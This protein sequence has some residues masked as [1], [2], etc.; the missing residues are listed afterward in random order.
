MISAV[1]IP[2]EIRR[3]LI[4]NSNKNQKGILAGWLVWHFYEMPRLLFLVWN[5]FISFGA[6]FFSVP[7]LISTL[8][9]PWRRY[10]WRYPRGFNIGGY[11]ETFVSNMFSRIVG[12]VC[13]SV[14]VVVGLLAMV[15]IFVLGSIAIL[16]WFLAPFILV[17]LVFFL[18]Y[19][20]Q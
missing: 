20:P 8:F 19:A 17:I 13:R 5:N 14:L 16:F 6:E 4:M 11:F 9:S 1:P 10:K 18:F 2:E 15:F 7:I 3:E 12:A